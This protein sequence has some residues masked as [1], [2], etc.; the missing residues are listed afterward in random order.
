M[1]PGALRILAPAVLKPLPQLALRF[2][3]LQLVIGVAALGRR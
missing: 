1:T 2:P 3:F